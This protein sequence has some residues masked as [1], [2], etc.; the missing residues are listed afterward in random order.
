MITCILN[1]H[2]RGLTLK[3]LRS[4]VRLSRKVFIFANQSEL[5]MPLEFRPKFEKIVELLLYLA[6]KKKGA[7]K[8][9]AVKFF[10]LADKLHLERFGRPITFENYYALPYGPVASEAKDLLEGNGYVMRQAGIKE[11]P[12][13]IEYRDRSGPDNAKLLLLGSPKRDVDFDVFSKSDIKVFD[14][15]LERY[16]DCDFDELYTITHAHNAYIKAWKN[17][18]ASRRSLMSYSDMIESDENRERILRDIGPVS[19][20]M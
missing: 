16:G 2:F 19:A 3:F 9:Q 15:I 20:R 5:F 1:S 10:Y 8:Y 12:F 6:H 7:D 4:V 17:R 13:E 14:E 18:G 11:L